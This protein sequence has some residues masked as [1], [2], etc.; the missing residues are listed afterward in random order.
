MEDFLPSLAG[1]RIVLVV[2]NQPLLRRT[3]AAGILGIHPKTL[4]A[5]A[6]DGLI[7][8]VALPSGQR[9]YRREDIEAFLASSTRAAS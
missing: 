7:P 9:R 5:N 6:R 2:S 8:F 3:E 4:D 1:K